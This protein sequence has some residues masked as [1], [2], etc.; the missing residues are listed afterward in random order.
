MKGSRL[1]IMCILAFLL[2]MFAVEY[3]LP[4]KFVWIPTYNS[5]DKQPF[6]CAIF[7]SVLTTSLPNGYS[8]SQET[9]YQLLED[10]ASKKGILVIAKDLS[11]GSVDV[12]ALMELAERG[13]KIM[14][15]ASSFSKYLCDTLKFGYS[16]SY[17]NG[18][19]FKKN[20]ASMLER[21]SL[22]WIGDSTVYSKQAFRFYPQLCNG[23]F[24]R[25]DSLPMT[26]LAQKNLTSDMDYEVAN[27]DSLPVYRNYHPLVAFSRAVGEGEVILVSTPLLF[28]NYGV[29][30][31]DNATYLFRLLSRMKG[32]PIVRTEAYFEEI[33]EDQ[34]S[35]LR[36]F[37][38]Q[39]P[40]RWGVYLT[41][42]TLVLF[43]I[44][45]A[46]R[47]QRPIPVMKEPVN[48][49]LEFTELIGTLYYQ[50]KNYADL[51]CKKFIYFAEEL[52]RSIQV[53]VED[54]SDDNGLCHRIALKTG[55]EEEK[56]R[57][58]F[59]SLRP[60]IRGDR[61]I[62]EESMKVYIDGMNEII[63]HL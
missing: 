54:D 62:S 19:V 27:M 28:T 34:Q 33:P 55:L 15:V 40:L 58:F 3:R 17:F 26:A 45:T 30:D 14:L 20:V 25:C 57:T 10:T 49:G 16:H 9:F 39:R 50:K 38:S 11:L 53:D 32:L 61:E 37:L 60:V 13:N 21:R 63:N 43:M 51:V 47:K 46:R 23:H 4:K 2:V 7:D 52:R 24:L 35:P 1:F 56:M 29:L 22:Y 5:S 31:G 36:Y 8:L 44:F 59:R 42:I 41:M 48:K 12:E 18:A 6:G